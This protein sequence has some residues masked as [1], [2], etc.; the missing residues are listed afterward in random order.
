LGAVFAELLYFV[1]FENAEGFAG[2]VWTI[3]I[4]RVEDV[5]EFVAVK[6]IE[7]SIVSIEFSLNEATALRVP[8]EGF[9]VV[10]HVLG[11]GLEIPGGVS[12]LKN[13]RRNEVDIC[14]A[15]A[16]RRNDRKLFKYS[17]RHIS[18]DII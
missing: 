15:I 2:E 17:R 5:A 7:V 6:A 9:T 8:N 3:D 12:K 10:T 16:L 1:I 4:G 11:E 18:E 13:T 14:L